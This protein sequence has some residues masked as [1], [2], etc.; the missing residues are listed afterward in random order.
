MPPLDE[1]VDSTLS[2]G[3]L[4]HE[5]VPIDGSGGAARLKAA[6]STTPARPCAPACACWKKPSSASNSLRAE[7]H[8]GRTSGP[9]KNADAVFARLQAKYEAQANS[10]AGRGS[11]R[12]L[13][14]KIV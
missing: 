13:A 5:L 3:R 4:F 9:R 2:A 11:S 1:S 14:V 8:A 6:A 7:I 10:L 12:H